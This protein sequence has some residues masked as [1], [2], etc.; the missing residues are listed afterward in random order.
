[1]QLLGKAGMG[2]LLMP[3]YVPASA[4]FNIDAAE[5]STNDVENAIW[6]FGLRRPWR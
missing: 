3:D 1:M 5:I 4:T 2:A 6:N